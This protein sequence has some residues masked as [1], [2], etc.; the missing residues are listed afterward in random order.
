MQPGGPDR[1]PIFQQALMQ[2]S[3]APG[4]PPGAIPAQP[5]GGDQRFGQPVND[6]QFPGNLP[7]LLGL[8]KG[9]L[10]KADPFQRSAFGKLEG[11][12]EQLLGTLQNYGASAF[13]EVNQAFQT[14]QNNLTADLATR[15]LASSTLQSADALGLEREQQSALLQLSDQLLGR[16]FDTV[17]SIGS[18]LAELLANIGSMNQQAKLN[19]KAQQQAADLQTPFKAKDAGQSRINVKY[20]LVGA[21]H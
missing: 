6:F 5:F 4:L 9:E 2:Q 10:G 13:N 17:S 20:N 12:Q 11:M 8:T 16:K 14:R 19:Q 3:A 15:G 1:I 18:T 21:R 7:E